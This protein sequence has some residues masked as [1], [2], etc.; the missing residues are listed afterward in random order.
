MHT[1]ITLGMLHIDMA[2]K[3][4]TKK[5]LENLSKQW[6]RSLIATKLTM[7]EVQIVNQEDAQIVSKIDS[8]VKIGRNT[9]IVPFGTI[10]V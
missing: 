6:E 8:T 4:A 9:T 7:K 10:K 3:Q 5:E 1:P 2:I